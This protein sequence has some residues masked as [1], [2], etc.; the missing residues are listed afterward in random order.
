MLLLTLGKSY[1]DCLGVALKS[2]TRRFAAPY[3]TQSQ[4]TSLE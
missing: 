3:V 4:F 1:A 2:Q